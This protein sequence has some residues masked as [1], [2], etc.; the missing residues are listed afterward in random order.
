VPD[1]KIHAAA[2]ERVFIKLFKH[3]CSQSS[4]YPV[5]QHTQHPNA[6]IDTHLQRHFDFTYIVLCPPSS[7]FFNC[8]LF[9]L[10]ERLAVLADVAL[11]LCCVFHAFVVIPLEAA[12]A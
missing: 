11:L 12:L 4:S 7:H 2:L 8:L 5:V 3:L 10:V 1:E 9:E 6:V